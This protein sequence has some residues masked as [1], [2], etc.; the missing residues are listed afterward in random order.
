M[1]IDEWMFAGD[2]CILLPTGLERKKVGKNCRGHSLSIRAKSLVTEVDVSV[3][4][5]Q[6]SHSQKHAPRLAFLQA[7]CHGVLL[8]GL[9][10]S[11]ICGREGIF[12]SSASPLVSMCLAISNQH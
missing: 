5:W 2:C 11:T 12:P 10:P 4:E 3:V 8:I 7:G 6:I 1:A 9:A